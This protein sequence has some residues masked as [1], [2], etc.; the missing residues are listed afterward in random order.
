MFYDGFWCGCLLFF[1]MFGV[2]FLVFF[3]LFVVNVLVFRLLYVF[4]YGFLLISHIP[5]YIFTSLS[6]FLLLLYLC[7]YFIFTILQSNIIRFL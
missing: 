7:S 4:C 2:C 6:T 1:I 3:D 5:D